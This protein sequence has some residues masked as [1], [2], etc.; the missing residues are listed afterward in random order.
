MDLDRGARLVGGFEAF[1]SFVYD[2]K[3]WPS[4][5]VSPAECYR[6]GGQYVVRATGGIASIGYGETDAGYIEA[7]WA[8]GVTEPDAFARLRARVA[9]FSEGV[10]RLIDAPMTAHQHEA[11]TS[12]AY[13]IGLAGTEENPGFRE[14][15]VRRRFNA[16]D[17]AGAADAFRMWVIPASL[18]D[19]REAEIA[20]FLTPDE[21]TAVAVDLEHLHPTFRAR[22]D[23]ALAAFPGLDVYSAGRSTQ[24]QAELRRGWELRLPGYNPANKPGTSW[25]EYGEGI[26]GGRWALAVDFDTSGRSGA[27][28]RSLRARASEFGLCFP[29]PDEEWHA[30]PAEITESYRLDGADGRLPA[31]SP[32]EEEFTMFIFDAPPERGG[33]VWQSDGVLRKPV[34]TG[35]TWPDLGDDGAKVAKHIGVCEIGTFDDLIDI[36]AVLAELPKRVAALVV[37]ALA[38]R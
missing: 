15:T 2:D 18:K 16:G 34:R 23:R 32:D 26:P 29:V 31:A 37:K 27:A 36:E 22:V 6:R 10:D 35:D 25:H 13:N 5:A 9:E 19:R 24:R 14:S 20:H 17:V 30:Q 8:S 11:M 12:L 38:E 1:R 3:T 21:E 33:G 28:L 7:H 4:V